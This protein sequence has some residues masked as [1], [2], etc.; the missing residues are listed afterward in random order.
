[1]AMQFSSA[2]SP[3]VFRVDGGPGDRVQLVG[4]E[5]EVI[6]PQAPAA[7]PGLEQGLVCLQHAP[8]GRQGLVVGVAA[9]VRG[10]EVVGEVG[11]AVGRQQVA[12]V[13][14][15]PALERAGEVGWFAP[16]DLG[17]RIF[18]RRSGGSSATGSTAPARTSTE[19]MTRPASAMPRRRGGRAPRAPV[20]K[21]RPT[22]PRDEL[23]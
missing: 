21:G 14:Q 8:V 12:G 6:R 17:G 13:V 15:Q 16:E 4:A 11:P 20:P 5:Q 19:G 2:V 10:V 22:A 18:T 23:S 1:M 7:G 3:A 9:V